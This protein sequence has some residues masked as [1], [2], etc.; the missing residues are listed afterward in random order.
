MPRASSP[1]RLTGLPTY[2]TGLVGRLLIEHAGVR[3][4][5]IA[6][7][8]FAVAVLALCYCGFD[9]VAVYSFIP[10]FAFGLIATSGLYWVGLG[11]IALLCFFVPVLIFALHAKGLSA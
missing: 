9:Y 3:T 2:D 7:A 11:M 6:I 8:A 4:K 1:D 10:G 5:E